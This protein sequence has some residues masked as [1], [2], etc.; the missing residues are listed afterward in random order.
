MQ[1]WRIAQS[2]WALDTSCAGA[3]KHGGRWNP[4]GLGAMYAGTTIELCALEM[5]THL[6][7]VDH[8]PLKLVAIDVPDTED[9]IFRPRL[10][11]IPAGWA[12]L[13]VATASQQF[14]GQ[15]LAQARQLVMLL[16]SVIVPE[17]TNALINPAHPA[18]ADIRLRAVRD[19]QFDSR[20]FKG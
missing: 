5:F 4:P 10:D 12:A 13:P 16:P 18:F 17:A 2:R 3:R 8:P 20:M 14:G 15:W 6:A 7:S 1:L 9:L 19:F 11:D